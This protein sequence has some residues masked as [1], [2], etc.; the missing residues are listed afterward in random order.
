MVFIDLVKAFDSVPREILFTVLRRFGL[1][2]HFVNIVIRLHTNSKLVMKIGEEEAEIGCNVGVR[3]GSCEGPILFLFV[4]Q[5]LV[6]TIRWPKGITL[7]TFHT[8][9]N[10]KLRENPNRTYGVDIFELWA[11]LFADDLALMF[12][13]RDSVTDGLKYFQK[14]ALRF[15]LAIHVGKIVG[16]N[17]IKSKTVAM[18]FPCRSVRANDVDLSN[19]V[20]D[21]DGNFIPIVEKTKYLGTIIHNSL[22]SEEDVIARVRVASAA[23]AAL[24]PIFIRRDIDPKVKGRIYMVMCVSILLYGGETWCMSEKLMS[25]L[26]NFHHCC[27]R[28]MCRVN[29]RMTRHYHISASVLLRRVGLENIEHY[30][31]SRIL[32]LAGHIVRMPMTRLPRK[33]LTSWIPKPR[34]PG[35][36]FNDWHVSVHEALKAKAITTEFNQWSLLAQDR[37]RWVAMINKK[38]KEKKT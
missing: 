32:R 8:A 20:L 34:P 25:R 21:S 4:M 13:T 11:T 16:N 9:S 15:G 5:A 3:Q 12:E 37:S 14:H 30:Y 23:F 10:A 31:H 19:I 7:P 29:L 28:F 36:P 26:R 1:P 18:F 24:R 17:E 22:Q 27:V 6:E 2:D 35:H 38:P 33:L